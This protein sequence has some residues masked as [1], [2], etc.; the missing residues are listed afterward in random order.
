[1]AQQAG[2]PTGSGQQLV[3]Q[4]LV[5]ESRLNVITLFY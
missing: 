3:D 5:F 4:K 1:V 2:G